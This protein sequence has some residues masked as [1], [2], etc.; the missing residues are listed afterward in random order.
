MLF[1]LMLLALMLSFAPARSQTIRKPV[2]PDL[3]K[4]S[5]DQITEQLNAWVDYCNLFI[6]NEPGYAEDYTG[7]TIAARQGLDMTPENQPL[8]RSIFHYLIGAASTDTDSAISHLEKAFTWGQKAG[9]PEKTIQAASRLLTLHLETG[10]KAGTHQYRDVLLHTADTAGDLSLKSKIYE[11]LSD[12]YTAIG[13]YETTLDYALKNIQARKQLLEQDKTANAAARTSYGVALGITGELFMNMNQPEK[14]LVY[15]RKALPL[16]QQYQAA[17]ET[18]WK[19]LVFIFSNDG[20]HDSAR[21]YYQMLVS[22]ADTTHNWDALASANLGMAS[23]AIDTDRPEAATQHLNNAGYYTQKIKSPVL[24]LQLAMLQSKVHIMRNGYASVVSL[25]TPMAPFA[26]DY[27]IV[28]YRD[29]NFLLAQAHQGLHNYKDAAFY[30]KIYATLADSIASQKV[31]ETLAEKEARYQHRQ[32]LQ[33]IELLSKKNTIQQLEIENARRHRYLLS[34]AL[35]IS[36]VIALL[37]YIIYRNKEK[38]N[39]LLNEKNEALYKLNTALETAN[40]TKAKLFGIIS[41]DLRAPI[42]KIY[43][44]LHLKKT[45]AISNETQHEQKMEHATGALLETI[46]DLLLWSKS[47]MSQFKPEIHPTSVRQCLD[48]AMS[49]VAGAAEEKNL[50]VRMDI[51]ESSRCNTDESFFK[52]ILRNLL[53]NAFKYATKHTVIH[54]SWRNEEKCLRITN[55][56]EQTDAATLNEHLNRYTIRSA[57]SGL[58]LQ[59][60]ADLAKQIEAHIRFEQTNVH[61]LTVLVYF[62][63][64]HTS[65]I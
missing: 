37:L 30:Y 25:L 38:N 12:Y 15:F 11:A 56:T 52:I 45:G 34:G 13:W 3:T 43:Q 26:R 6:G 10:N 36:G 40:E 17:H 51:P 50:E 29:L 28:D 21:H 63:E 1:R 32:Q 24:E 65:I 64:K 14:A 5:S 55:D 23:V 8:F 31:S 58:G 47:Q 27:N 22:S 35:A 62:P 53:Q 59:M 9:S 2:P 19:H 46:E 39:Q 44:F 48:E 60:V 33:D 57:H 16:I 41:H 61:A 49:L 18:I 54:V 42:S 20:Q 4:Y 7:L